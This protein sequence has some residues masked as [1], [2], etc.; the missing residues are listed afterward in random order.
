MFTGIVTDL[1]KVLRIDGAPGRRAVLRTAYLPDSLP[2]G[3]S[4]AC[5]GVCLT[6]TAKGADAEGAW[7]ALDISAE[8]L[9][10]TTLGGWKPGTAVN[11]E[12]PLKIGD[13]LG[14]HIVAGHVDGVGHV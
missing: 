14:G 12:R 11:L 5:A 10:C 6:V 2:L 4:V 3:A 13:E 9:R 1:G 7:M 8:T